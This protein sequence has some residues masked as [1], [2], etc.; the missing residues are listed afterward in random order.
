MKNLLFA[1]TALLVLSASV[2]A[3]DI[4]LAQILVEK[5]GW[6]VVA[7]KLPGITALE[8]MP[9]GALAIYQGSHTATLNASGT[10]EP[11]TTKR[12][13]PPRAQTHVF[14]SSGNYR[15]DPEAKVVVARAGGKEETLQLHGLTTPACLT[16]WPDQGHLVIG[17]SASAW[18]WAVRIEKDGTLGPG[19]RYYSLQVP[20]GKS[21]PVTAMTID[22][23]GLLYAC[24]PRGVQVFDPTGR[25]SGVIA[26]PGKAPMTAIAL[27]GPKADTLFVAC[28][29]EIHARPLQRKA[30]YTLKKSKQ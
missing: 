30:S 11:I 20:R 10:L 17:E 2:P 9:N 8:G 29:D 26:L 27:G 19:D 12:A 13:T 1:T 28:G 22:A 5:Q 14:T 18:L 15:I 24:T 4:P 6:R 25:L 16:L 21:V 7:S 3:Q 23:S